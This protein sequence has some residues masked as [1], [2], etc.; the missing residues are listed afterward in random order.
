MQLD[1]IKQKQKD[2]MLDK[3]G[4]DHNFKLRDKVQLWNE[5]VYETLKEEWHDVF[6]PLASR[7]HKI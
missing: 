3:Y 6:V 2:T 7:Q 4:V 1:S 5:Y